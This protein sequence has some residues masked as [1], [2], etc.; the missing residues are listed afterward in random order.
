MENLLKYPAIIIEKLYPDANNSGRILSMD[1]KNSNIRQYLPNNRIRMLTTLAGYQVWNI[2]LNIRPSLPDN[3]ILYLTGWISSIEN[4]FK[5]QAI[6]TVK[7]YPDA[8]NSGRILSLEKF[9]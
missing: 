6:I 7:L 1:K 2:C 5:Y 3:L 9:A 4:L 8:N